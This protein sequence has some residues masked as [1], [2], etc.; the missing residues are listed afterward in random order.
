MNASSESG[1]WA[2]LISRTAV[3]TDEDD[4]LEILQHSGGSCGRLKNLSQLKMFFAP[5]GRTTLIQLSF[6]CGFMLRLGFDH[7]AGR[8]QM[9]ASQMPAQPPQHGGNGRHN[10]HYRKRQQHVQDLHQHLRLGYQSCSLPT[11]EK[12]L[13][14]LLGKIGRAS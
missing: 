1:L 11:A 2:M 14:R 5:G 7:R 10:G 6:F 9:R 13:R 3:E 8:S 4:I 12:A